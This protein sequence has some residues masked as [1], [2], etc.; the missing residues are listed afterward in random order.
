MEEIVFSDARQESFATKI[1]QPFFPTSPMEIFLTTILCVISVIVLAY[2]LV[3]IYRCVCSRNYAEWRTSWN[4][5]KIKDDKDE[6]FLLEAVPV[7]VEGHQHQI[8]CLATD[9]KQ[10][11]SACLGKNIINTSAKFVIF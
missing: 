9:G 10:I 11:I 5:D 4:K 2:I 7:V 3:V 1:D 6:H 8:E